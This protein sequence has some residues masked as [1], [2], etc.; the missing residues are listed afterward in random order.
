M[1]S[2][3]ADNPEGEGVKVGRE[4]EEEPEQAEPPPPEEVSHPVSHWMRRMP[5]LTLRGS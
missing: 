1:F 5:T 4:A 3:S 2:V